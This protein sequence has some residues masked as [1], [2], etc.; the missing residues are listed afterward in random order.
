MSGAAAA[1]SLPPARSNDVDGDGGGAA[2]AATAAAPL[3]GDVL[4]AHVA[5]VE[6]WQTVLLLCQQQLLSEQAVLA[7]EDA[8]PAPVAPVPA[9]TAKRPRKRPYKSEAGDAAPTTASH[10]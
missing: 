10:A 6:T 5:A 3:A 7:L 2:A 8:P 4:D 9:P 1:P